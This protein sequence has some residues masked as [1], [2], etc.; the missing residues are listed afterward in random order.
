MIKSTSSPSFY[1]PLMLSIPRKI[2]FCSRHFYSIQKN[3]INNR[4]ETFF[5]CSAAFL[6]EN[7][8]SF[9]FFPRWLKI[10]KLLILSR[11]FQATNEP[12]LGKRGKKLGSKKIHHL[13]QN[14]P[15]S[16][17]SSSSQTEILFMLFLLTE[18]SCFGREKHERTISSL[19]RTKISTT[20]MSKSQEKWKDS[21]QHT[22]GNHCFVFHHKNAACN[23]N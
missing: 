19:F 6:P 7:K 9:T 4:N 8:S 11:P 16:L 17:S 21:K 2:H 13:R 22:T 3:S 20:T 5:V 18:W 12:F 14:D 10:K 15:N 23:C 1:H